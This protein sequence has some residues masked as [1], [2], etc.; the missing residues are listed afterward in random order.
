MVAHY[1][2]SLKEAKQGKAKETRYEAHFNLASEVT[3]EVG[4]SS[5]AI[6]EAKNNN[7]YQVENHPGKDDMIM[8]FTSN[9]LFGDFA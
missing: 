4:C 3:K 5:K 6:V 7:A 1:Q 2:K 9:D 8:E